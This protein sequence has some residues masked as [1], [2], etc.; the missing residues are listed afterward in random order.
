MSTPKIATSSLPLGL[1]PLQFLIYGYFAVLLVGFA[2]L[3]TPW[4]EVRDV[5]VLDHFFIATSALSTTG[6]ATLGV[7]QDYTTFGQVV[8]LALI[9][10]GGL[11]Y[12]SLGSF[13]VL[14]RKR[15]LSG[16]HNEL[17]AYDF[18]LPAG[19]DVQH[20]IRRLV[21]FTLA[22]EG[23]GALLL[24]WVFAARGEP[25]AL[26]NGVFHSISAFCT[27]GFSLFANGFEDYPGHFALNL[28]VAALATL[29]ALGFIV[30]ADVSTRFGP[31]RRGLTFTSRIILRFT[32]AGI[33]LGTAVLF[34]SDP[35]TGA[36]PA[37]R[38]LLVAFFQSM[39]AFTTVGFNTVPIAA[40][41]AAPLFAILMLMIV[42]ASPSGTGGGMKSTTFT[43]LWAQLKSTFAGRSRT[44]YMNRVVPEHRVRAA[45]SNFFFYVL[46][47]VGGVYALLLVQDEE[48][49]VVI[50]EA[51]SALGTVGLSLGLTGDLTPLGKV[52]VCVLMFLGR[53]GP[54]SAGLVLFGTEAIEAE[55]IEED[56]AI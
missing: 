23:V 46:V 55:P 39:T 21:V 33:A 24:W 5:S 49:F 27:A 43:A 40:I 10:I 32:A 52:I 4:A 6:L 22:A 30:V 17:L 9:Q 56:L 1:P 45:V 12:M 53:V 41:G 2:L 50:F 26:W 14:M 38:G 8:V 18:S 48:P 25:Q 51:V 11:G 37:E 42:G 34:L 7:G 36:M 13:V 20:F 35:A 54:L 28:V 29:G 44:L 47:L 16:G 3:C 31:Q 15:E 19:F